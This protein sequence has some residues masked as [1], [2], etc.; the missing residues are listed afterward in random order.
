VHIDAMPAARE[1][2][3]DAVMHQAFAPQTLA[4]AR[5]GEQIH[6]A[7]LQYARANSLFGMFAGLSFDDHGINSFEMEQERED[8][9]GRPGSDDADLSAKF[10]GGGVCDRTKLDHKN[11]ESN[12]LDYHG[13]ALANPDAHGA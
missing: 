3:F 6:R 8:Q 1:A 11:L 9:A 2:Q 10:A 5:L 12:A 7:L 13:D 4:D